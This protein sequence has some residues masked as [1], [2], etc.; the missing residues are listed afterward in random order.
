MVYSPELRGT[1]PSWV[2]LLNAALL[3]VYQTADGSDG[4]QARRTGAG[5]ALGHLFDHGLDSMVG[6]MISMW[7]VDVFAQGTG[8][9]LFPLLVGLAQL[10]F[11]LSN[12]VCVHKGSQ[13]FYPV[14]VQEVELSIML[15]C[16][17]RGLYGGAFWDHTFHVA[18][19]ALPVWYCVGTASVVGAI[20]NSR[21]YVT[22]V[23]GPYYRGTACATGG[24]LGHALRHVA[25]VA[26]HT[27]LVMV[28]LHRLPAVRHP[29]YVGT[30]VSF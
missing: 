4:K 26:A 25:C 18:G 10:A 11:F 5:S 21:K 28:N 20:D 12:L 29:V 14:D 8:H 1:A 17:L 27:G 24:G 13:V 16:A 22:N 3:F 30:V 19:Y 6:T 2:Y 9:P 15:V 7:T 23:L